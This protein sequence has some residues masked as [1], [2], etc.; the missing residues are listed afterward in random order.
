[1]AWEDAAKLA[2]GILG[3]IAMFLIGWNAYELRAM[4]DVVYNSNSRIAVMEKEQAQT[5]ERVK[6]I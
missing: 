3:S 2:F 4:R 1:M 6:S 5:I